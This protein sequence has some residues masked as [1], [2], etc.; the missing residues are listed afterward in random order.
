MES[1]ISKG[2]RREARVDAFTAAV[3]RS[4][5]NFQNVRVVPIVSGDSPVVTLA[6]RRC[7]KPRRSRTAAIRK[8]Y[9]TS[10]AEVAMIMASRMSPLAA[11][12]CAEISGATT[13][14][15]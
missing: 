12:I 3:I 7:Y 9:R 6:A 15:L 4:S 13:P 1:E 8:P 10:G 2:E 11:M 14:A 5:L